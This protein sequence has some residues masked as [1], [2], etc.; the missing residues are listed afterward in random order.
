MKYKPNTLRDWDHPA[1]CDIC[2][3][4]FWASTMRWS[5]P[6]SQGGK[7]YFVDDDCWD[8][9]H[10]GNK[11]KVVKEKRTVPVAR[12]LVLDDDGPEYDAKTAAETEFWYVK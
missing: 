11:V 2:G 1:T 9:Y 12:P 4:R 3:D 7:Q 8:P 10:E 6:N 5:S